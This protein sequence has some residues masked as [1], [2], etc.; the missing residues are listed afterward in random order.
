[1]WQ[2]WLWTPTK[3]ISSACFVRLSKKQCLVITNESWGQDHINILWMRAWEKAVKA[4]RDEGLSIQ[5]ACDLHGVKRGTLH[6]AL[7]VKHQNT[8]GGMTVFSQTEEWAF[9]NYLMVVNE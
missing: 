4:C 7:K 5:D 8:P 9:V 1:M 2:G 6:N 3:C